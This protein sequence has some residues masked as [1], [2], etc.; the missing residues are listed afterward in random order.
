MSSDEE[1]GTAIATATPTPSLGPTAAT[2]VVSSGRGGVCNPM[3]LGIVAGVLA[4]AGL[5]FVG[6]PILKGFDCDLNDDSFGSSGGGD[7]GG[8]VIVKG[9]VITVGLGLWIASCVVCCC[10]CGNASAG[11]GGQ[12]TIV[13][14]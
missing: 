5:L 9:I 12:S 14:R 10:L 4:V 13:V 6:I 3:C 1:K 2:A 7:C 8:D 11:G